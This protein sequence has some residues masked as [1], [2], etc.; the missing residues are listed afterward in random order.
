MRTLTRSLLSEY[1]GLE[2]SERYFSGAGVSPLFGDDGGTEFVAFFIDYIILLSWHFAITP[3]YLVA[4]GT[5]R[6]AWWNSWFFDDRCE[7]ASFNWGVFVL[8]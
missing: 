2:T 3:S 5:R 7:S 6:D 4:E 1:A 8:R